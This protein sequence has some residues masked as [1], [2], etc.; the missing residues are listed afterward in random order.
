MS[1]P[2]YMKLYIAD[3]HAETTTL[4]VV[5]H[6]AYMLLLMAMWRAGGKLPRDEVKL[7]KLAKC[8]P[9]QWAVVRDDVLDH[10]TVNGGSI[11]HGRVRKEIA[12]YKNVVSGSK[13]GG[14]ASA[15]KRAIKNSDIDATNGST[16]VERLLNQPEPEP[17]RKLEAKASL[18]SS[19]DATS[20]PE[21]KG[22]KKPAALRR[23]YPE[24]FELA[25]KAY[26][27]E[28]RRS[29]KPNSFE[30]W[31][32]LPDDE[33]AALPAACANFARKAMEV[34]GGQGAQD[35]ATWLRD[36]KHLNWMEAAFEEPRRPAAKFRGPD[37]VR[38]AIVERI[39]EEA[40][41]SYVDP[42]RWDRDNRVLLVAGRTA[43]DKLIGL[44]GAWAAHV[45][46]RVEVEPKPSTAHQMLGAPA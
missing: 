3:Y 1:A 6:G 14:E 32:L 29:S 15:A 2:P 21:G 36:G 40:V 10:F 46:M 7:A 22:R 43:R 28:K 41:R 44:L 16:S 30:F 38:S 23:D 27:D 33:R 18:S 8:T 26:P 39:G 17:E 12:K 25:W 9:E 45:K 11:T 4:D 24:L 37:E 42:G 31:K 19:D 13:R 34:T 20:K 5:G 35:M